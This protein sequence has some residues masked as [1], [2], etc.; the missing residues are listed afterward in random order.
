MKGKICGVLALATLFLLCVG[1]ASAAGVSDVYHGV[2]GGSIRISA[3][4][5][6]ISSDAGVTEAAIPEEVGGIAVTAIGKNAFKGRS[7]LKKVVI[8]D[9]VTTIGADAFNGAALEEV[10]LPAGATLE[11]GAFSWCRYVK[12]V[13]F[14]GTGAMADFTDSYTWTPWYSGCYYNDH[15][16]EVTI[17]SGVTS[18]GAHA[19]HN[20][21][22]LVKVHGAEGVRDIGASAFNGCSSLGDLAFV[23]YADAIG[24]YAFYNC[25]SATGAVTIKDGMEAVAAHAFQGCKSFTELTIPDSVKAIGADAF[26]GCAGITDAVIPGDLALE[27][28]AFSWCRGASRI[29]YTGNGPMADFTDTYAWSLCYSG[30]YYN[31]HDVTVEIAPGV[32]S[33]GA[34]AFHSCGAL[35]KATVADSVAT[36]GESAFNGCSKLGDLDFVKH[37]DEIGEYAFYGCSSATGAVT[38]KDGMEAVAAHAFQGCK[39]F[40]ELTIPDSVK[41]IG[42]DAFNGCAGITDAVIPGDLALESGA[43]SWC[44]GAS[45]ITYT[46]NGPMADFTDTYAWS[47]CYSGCY[48]NDHDVTVEIAPGVTSV[49][50]HAFH[51]CGALVKAT[52]ADSVATIGESAFN[53]CSKLGDLSFVKY[54]DEIGEYAFYSCSSATGA[55]TIRDGVEE[56]AAHAF[57][58][59]SSLQTLTLPESLKT[60]NADAFNGCSKLESVALPANIT[61]KDGA[62]SWCRGVSNVRFIGKGEMSDFSDV[63]TW[64]PWYS[65]CYYNDHDVAIE[66]ASGVTSVGANAFRSCGR[67][68]SVTVPLSVTR[69]GANAFYD[70]STLH[71]YYAGTETQWGDVVKTLSKKAPNTLGNTELTMHYGGAALLEVKAADGRAVFSREYSVPANAVAFVVGYDGNGKMTERQSRTAGDSLSFTLSD[72][73]TAKIRILL[74][75][76]DFAPL[77]APLEAAA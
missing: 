55:A 50:A 7:K 33:V 59:C 75:R 13:A 61:L 32:T 16:V 28:G 74:F 3:A 19:F 56:I 29:T 43:F 48:Y 37:A 5:V 62:F 35:V 12:R 44:R 6:V 34:H 76:E 73:R 2:E 57:Q 58:G 8:P 22:R 24:E 30:C 40:T 14:T 54:A 20:C 42:A 53:G 72:T 9:T 41:A 69:I 36:I 23:E 71:V 18:V 60:V 17:G 31:D 52:V 51:S 4:G 64:S 1:T 68:Q 26:N 38:I 67:V 66:I 45:R 27:S 49:G 63:Y 10:S 15:D 46:G 25:S 70:C 77:S 39:S 47:L 21:G 65:G 11:S